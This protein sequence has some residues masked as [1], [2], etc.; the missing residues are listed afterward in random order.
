MVGVTLTDF[1]WCVSAMPAPA[2]SVHF[3]LKGTVKIPGQLDNT[4]VPE[5]PYCVSR[6][7]GLG[8]AIKGH[9]AKLSDLYRHDGGPMALYFNSPCR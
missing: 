4:F 5:Q 1:V 2:L 9:E 7:V 3:E 6:E 8:V